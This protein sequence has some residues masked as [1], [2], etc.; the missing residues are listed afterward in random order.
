MEAPALIAVL[1]GMITSVFGGVLRDIVCN[2]IPKV[3]SDHRPY[4]LCA[5]VGGWVLV[6][7]DALGVAQWLGLVVAAAVA[8][9]F[10]MLAMR[11]D[12]QIPAWRV[13]R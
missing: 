6:A 3:F 7:L 5:F 8:S 2:D 11:F 12:W 9:L 10:R 13:D 1:M 4:A